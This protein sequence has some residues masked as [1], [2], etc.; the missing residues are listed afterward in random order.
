MD[1]SMEPTVRQAA[2][3]MLYRETAEGARVYLARRSPEARFFPG[4]YAFV[5]GGLSR[6][7][8]APGEEP[9]YRRCVVRELEE[10]LAVR[11]EPEDLRPAGRLLTPD[12]VPIRYDTRYYAAPCPHQDPRPA[13]PELVGGRWFRPD[14]ALELWDRG[15]ILL[16]S[17]VL[18]VLRTLREKGLEAGLREWAGVDT[19]GQDNEPYIE[20]RPGVRFL[21]LRG[22]T[23]PP[24]RTTNTLV[25]GAGGR[26]AGVYVVDPGAPDGED[27]D[28]LEELVERHTQAWGPLRAIL[29]THHHTDHAGAAGRLAERFR[30]P[31]RAHPETRRRLASEWPWGADVGDGERLPVGTHPATGDPVVL[32]AIHTPGHAPGHLAFLEERSR[33]LLAGDMV[34]GLG[35]ILVDPEEGD[36][37]AYM[38]S[39]ERLREL[40]PAVVLPGH[41]PFSDHPDRMLQGHLDHRRTREERVLGAL[42]AEPRSTDAL[43]AEVYDDVPEAYHPYAARSLLAHLRKLQE[44]GRARAEGAEGWRA[45]P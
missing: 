14:E 6:S 19:A 34:A 42:S 21:P 20:V 17:P 24:A 13:P 1:P 27:R 26:E 11:L 2:A 32:R 41:G 35:T 5:G 37:G 44:E 25:V 30:A 16:A 15:E 10:E 29:L 39:L 33:T 4:Y 3:A 12:F 45:A 38:R 18:L 7:D 40:A 23:L 31:I 8:G 22:P 43:L 36:M 28:R 9:T